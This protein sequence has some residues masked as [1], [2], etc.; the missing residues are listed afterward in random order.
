MMLPA[1]KIK[2]TLAISW[3]VLSCT[4]VQAQPVNSPLPA[5]NPTLNPRGQLNESLTFA[6]PPPPPDIGEPGQR[7]EA[8]SRGCENMDKQ[9]TFAQKQL[10]ALVPVYSNSELVLGATIASA[11]TFWFYIPYQP[12]FLGEFVLRD[13][14]GMLVYQ[15]DVTLPDTPGVVSLSLPQTVAPLEIGKQ[16]RWFLKVYCKAQ[17]PPAF[18]EGWVQRISLNPILKSQL[19]KATPRDRVALYA[20]NG[21]WFEALSIAGELRRRDP[22]APSWVVLLQA[23]G[24]TGLVN[25]PIVECCTPKG[26]E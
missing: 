3:A 16:Y 25:E 7:S 5:Q 22:N 13:K 26:E 6:A 18:V 15:T 12:P 23:V 20:A 1:Q 9:L 2:L 11:P 19:E 24:L 14:D 8:G 10:T 4:Q 17:E 21:I